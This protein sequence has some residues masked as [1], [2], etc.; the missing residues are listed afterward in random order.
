MFFTLAEKPD[1]VRI[2]IMGREKDMLFDFFIGGLEMLADTIEY[3]PTKAFEINA[4][5]CP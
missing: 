2:N 5:V 3:D 1:N 4:S